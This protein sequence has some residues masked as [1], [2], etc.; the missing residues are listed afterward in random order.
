MRRTWGRIVGSLRRL[1]IMD[2]EKAEEAL[3]TL[4]RI[5]K[6]LWKA[7]TG[8]VSTHMIDRLQLSLEKLDHQSVVRG[9]GVHYFLPWTEE[10]LR[11]YERNLAPGQENERIASTERVLKNGV[12][13]GYD[14]SEPW[15]TGGEWAQTMCSRFLAEVDIAPRKGTE[16]DELS[17]SCLT[18]WRYSRYVDSVR[19]L[20]EP[21]LFT[22]E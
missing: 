22:V 13:R 1:T 15:G 2:N 12:S 9:E 3:N 7:P 10:D 18:G 17:L 5:C 6:A 4:N 19:P 16:N 8:T 20:Y 11:R 14:K 21:D